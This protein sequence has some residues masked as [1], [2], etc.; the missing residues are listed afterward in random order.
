MI[1]VINKIDLKPDKE[2]IR[3]LENLIKNKN[4]IFKIS[5]TT[6]KNIKEL[7]ALLSRGTFPGKEKFKSQK[8][9]KK[10]DKN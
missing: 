4:N 9:K 5:T 1:I 3:K 2:I 7:K 8:N 10:S 6:G